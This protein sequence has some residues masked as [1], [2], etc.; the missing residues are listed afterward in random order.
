MSLGRSS[1]DLEHNIVETQICSVWLA[2]WCN[3]C[4]HHCTVDQGLLCCRIVQIHSIKDC[5]LHRLIWQRVI[6]LVTYFYLYFLHQLCVSYL[7]PTEV[8]CVQEMSLQI[9]LYVVYYGH[10]KGVFLC[11]ILAN[12]NSQLCLN[13]T[14]RPLNF[15]LKTF[16]ILF[17]R[18]IHKWN[19]CLQFM[20]N[21][22]NNC[23]WQILSMVVLWFEINACICTRTTPELRL[24]C[25][26]VILC[27]QKVQC[28][29]Q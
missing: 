8:L 24:E 27:V 1:I 23:C 12:A 21:V 28:F 9:W 13:S 2:G 15:C 16:Q 4:G 17:C 6:L 14:N 25:V 7:Q 3:V 11:R 22:R 29:V 19:V 20:Q 10:L 26:C 18:W 5:N